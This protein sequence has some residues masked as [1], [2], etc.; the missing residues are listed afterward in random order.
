M[1]TLAFLN[2]KGGVGKTASTTTIG[3]I[4][5]E[6]YNKKVLLIDVDPQANTSTGFSE[7]DY[8][9]I[10]IGIIKGERIGRELSM[11]DLLMDSE[12][13]PHECIKHTKY[14]NLDI[15]PAYQTLAEAEEKLKADVRTPQQFR[16]KSQLDKVKDEYDFCIIDCSPSINI[17]NINALVAADEVYI[18][19]KTDGNSLIGIAISYN[20]IRTVQ[21]YNPGLRLMGAFFT[22]CDKRTNVTKTAREFLEQVLPGLLLPYEIGKNVKLEENSYQQATLLELDKNCRNHVTKTYVALAEYIQSD[23]RKK[24]INEY[25]KQK[26]MQ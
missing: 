21:T 7:M 17:L 11:E 1:K 13:D 10:F 3:H 24:C 8:F 22:Q 19:T 16:L 6:R 9:K 14:E 25:K 4:L 26:E 18:P 15:I 5:A 20:L 23:D 12:L 2:Q